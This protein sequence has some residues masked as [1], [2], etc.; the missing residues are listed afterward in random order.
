MVTQVHNVFPSP[1]TGPKSLKPSE[2]AANTMT[3]TVFYAARL[4]ESERNDTQII[5]NPE[6]AGGAGF[7]GTAGIAGFPNGE[8]T[9]RRRREPHPVYRSTVCASDIRLRG[10]AGVGTRRRKPGRRR[11]R[12]APA[13]RHRRQTCGSRH[14]GRQPLCPRSAHP[15]PQLGP[16]V[17]RRMGLPRQCPRI[18]LR[19]SRR[20]QPRRTGRWLMACSRSRQSQTALPSIGTS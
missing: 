4:C 12:R 11:A 2:P 16:G 19:R 3:G 1:Y 9:A 18:H 5:F 8:A 20:L 10:R 6:T 15:V 13:G 14:G 7:S 17:Q